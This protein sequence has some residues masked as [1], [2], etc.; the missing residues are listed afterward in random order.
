MNSAWQVKGEAKMRLRIGKKGKWV[1]L[2]PAFVMTFLPAMAH[3]T[4][5]N[6]PS[7][8]EQPSKAKQPVAG[9]DNSRVDAKNYVIGENDVLDIDV[10]KEK[11]ISRTIPVRP[12]GKISLPLIGEIQASGM[13][14]RWR[15]RCVVPRPCWSRSP[16]YPQARSAW[17]GRTRSCRC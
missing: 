13:T 1:I 10:W 3:Q 9:V 7:S 6:V 8:A 12:D 11:E 5:A 4:K 2:L 15:R 16:C 17:Q 14:R